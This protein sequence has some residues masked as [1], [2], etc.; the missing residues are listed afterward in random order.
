MRKPNIMCKV[1]MEWLGVKGSTLKVVGLT[2]NGSG[3]MS[4]SLC[5]KDEELFPVGSITTYYAH[6]TTCGCASN[7]KWKNNQ[8]LVLINRKCTEKGFIFH[9]TVPAEEGSITG[10]TKLVLEDMSSGSVWETTDV[11]HLLYSTQGCPSTGRDN[12]NKVRRKTEE[13]LIGDF[14]NTGAFKEGVKFKR[15]LETKSK[16]VKGRY[17]HFFMYCPTCAEDEYAKAGLSDGWFRTAISRLKKGSI[18]CR[19]SPKYRWT[20]DE[21]L[22]QIKKG[23]VERGFTFY[24]LDYNKGAFSSFTGLCDYN[25]YIKMTINGFINSKS[26]CRVCSE[27]AMGFYPQYVNRADTL[28][29]LDFGEFIKI[30]RSFNFDKRLS[31]LETEVGILPEVINLEYLSHIKVYNVEQ[32]IIKENVDKRYYPSISFAGMTECFHK[33]EVEYILNEVKYYVSETNK[34]INNAK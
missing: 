25:H 29:L 19:C 27:A 12:A 23:C 18:P 11:L 14:I 6:R 28:Y 22:Y 33:K 16:G 15:D 4:C 8:Y 20:E 21:R 17:K 13:A 26:G 9:S 1:G 30:G 34:E 24:N 32:R 5:D 7:T 2:N 3:I 10:K 31:Q